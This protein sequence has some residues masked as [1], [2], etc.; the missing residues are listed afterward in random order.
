MMPRLIV[1]GMDSTWPAR[2]GAPTSQEARVGDLGLLLRVNWSEGLIDEIANDP[3]RFQ[4]Q[5]VQLT[6][7]AR[8]NAAI[9]RR[10]TERISFF[11]RNGS[12]F[13]GQVRLADT[14]AKMATNTLRDNDLKD[15]ARLRRGANLVN[16]ICDIADELIAQA[17]AA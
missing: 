11:P 9:V 14:L 2:F 7:V 4:E 6:E 15:A 8:E 17:Q 13:Q 10:M 3:A 12:D 16:E 1:S 5:V